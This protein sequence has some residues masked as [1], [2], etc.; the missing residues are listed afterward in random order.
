[1]PYVGPDE[2][3]T[4]FFDDVEVEEERL[5]GGENGGLGPIFDGLNPERIMGATIACGVGRRA[6][7][8]ATAY[9]NERD[10]W[11]V[12]IG[13]HQ[14]VSHPLA[15][16]KIELELARLMT[17]KA[18][19]LYDA[20]APG[21]GRG[22][23]HGQVRCGR[24]G[25]QV[26]RP[27]DPDPRR[28]RLRARVR[29][30]RPVV[31][32]APDPHRA[33]VAR[34]DPQLRRRALARAAEVLLIGLALASPAS[35][36]VGAARE[37]A[38][39]R[40]GSVSFALRTES[41]L[42]GYRVQRSVPSASVL[43]AMLMVAYLRRLGVRD[44]AL[45]PGD[46]ALLAPMIRWSDNATATRVRNLVGNRAL[47]RL[48][49]RAGMRRFRTAPIWGQSRI[50]AADQ[51]RFFLRIDS[52]VPQ[53]HRAYAM[54]LLGSIVPS[55]RWGIARVRPPGW[56][57]YF[58]GGWGSGTGAVDHQVALLRRGSQRVAVA[59]LTTGSPS[60]AYGKETLRG[61]AARLLRGL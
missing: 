34:D 47:R 51:S 13:T 61:V 22:H 17:Q 42:Q 31:G 54:R 32:R 50:D 8:K 33:G 37:Y 4:L 44:R 15:E 21:R 53:R 23:Q 5:I 7:E 59:I 2:Q 1:M 9:A 6:L 29:P 43:K 16:A 55:Q 19:A 18:A 12:P 46:R 25:D 40:A 45:G 60:H 35:A 41:R 24:G 52:F 14:G 3:W 36:D 58:K 20:G 57:L 27:G 11:G 30:E 56:A 39:E 28:Q 10:V 48:A 26:R 38:G 49:R